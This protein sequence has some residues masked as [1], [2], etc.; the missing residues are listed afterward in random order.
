MWVQGQVPACPCREDFYKLVSQ[1]TMAKGPRGANAT[2]DFYTASWAQDSSQEAK[3]KTVVDLETDI[4][5]LM[6]TKM[7]V[8]QHR[9]SA[10]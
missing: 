2:F 9:A 7:A 1:V 8:A 3:K 6:P 4:N 5:F 10:K